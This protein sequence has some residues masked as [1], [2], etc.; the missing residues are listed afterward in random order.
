MWDS[1]HLHTAN[2]LPSTKFSPVY[3]DTPLCKEMRSCFSILYNSWWSTVVLNYTLLRFW[4]ADEHGLNT[5]IKQISVCVCVSVFA[6]RCLKRQLSY[7]STAFRMPPKMPSWSG[8][9]QAATLSENHVHVPCFKHKVCRFSQNPSKLTHCFTQKCFFI[10]YTVY[11]HCLAIKK[12]L[13]L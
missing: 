10:T 5:I 9:Q 8:C 7:S 2:Y 3:T 11:T 12:S 4:N 6:H 1:S 13:T